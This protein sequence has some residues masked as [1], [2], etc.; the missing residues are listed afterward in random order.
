MEI[1]IEKIMDDIRSEIKEKGYTADMLS[2][3]DVTGITSELSDGFNYHELT[4]NLNVANDIC[5]VPFDRPLPGNPIVVFIKKVIRKLIRF[6][7][8][9]TVEQQNDFNAQ[10]VRCVNILGNHAK[11]A[12][13]APSVDELSGKIE[14][15]ELKLATATKENDELRA[16]LDRLESAL[17]E[18]AAE[19]K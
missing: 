18:K 10:M 13:E 4:V 12:A 8:R 6:Y 5:M 9:P 3:S 17:S 14:L 1:N 7:I 2:F 11:A 16:R 15:L 19:N